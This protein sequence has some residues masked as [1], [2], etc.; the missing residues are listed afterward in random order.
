MSDE[1]DAVLNSDE[2]RNRKDFAPSLPKVEGTF[3][4][5][6]LVFKEVKDE[7][8]GRKFIAEFRV[9]KS[10]SDLVLAKSK[11]ALIWKTSGFKG[12]MK[13]AAEAIR[14]FLAACEGQNAEDESFDP[15]PIKQAYLAA[16]AAGEAIGSK[17]RITRRKGKPKPSKKD[18]NE[19]GTPKMVQYYNDSFA[20]LAG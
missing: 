4:V 11:Y 14:P 5:E 17:I 18:K 7:E 2:V 13:M 6:V 1:F 20:T 9:D 10:N 16:F 3:D 19:D 12:A 15:I 8:T